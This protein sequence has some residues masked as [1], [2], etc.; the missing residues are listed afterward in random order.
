MANFIDFGTISWSWLRLNMTDMRLWG[1]I[2]HFLGDLIN[3]RIKDTF[4]IGLCFNFI[5]SVPFIIS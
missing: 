2:T 4:S 3:F 1:F 5:K